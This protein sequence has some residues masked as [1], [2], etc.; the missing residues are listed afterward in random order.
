MKFASMRTV[1]IGRKLF[2]RPKYLSKL[3]NTRFTTIRLGIVKPKY[4]EV[5][6][7]SGRS[8]VG[9][10]RIVRVTYKRFC[11]LTMEDAINDGFRNR[12]DLV[13]ELRRIYGNIRDDDIV[14]VIELELLRLTGDYYRWPS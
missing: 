13:K 8:I 11:E 2:L 7:Q 5:Y 3:A 4:S 1:Y 6:I 10:A 12:E 14:T 9:K